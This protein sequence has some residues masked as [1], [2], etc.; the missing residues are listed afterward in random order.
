[1]QRPLR[2]PLACYRCQSEESQIRLDDG[3]LPQDDEKQIPEKEISPTLAGGKHLLETQTQTRL[4]HACQNG[5]I[6]TDGMFLKSP[7]LQP[8]DS[9]FTFQKEL[10]VNLFY[11]A[12]AKGKN[13]RQ[14]T[15]DRGQKE[16][17]YGD[18]DNG[19][20]T[21]KGEWKEKGKS[22]GIGQRED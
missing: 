21:R 1:L 7:D 19:K 14:M 11:K 10:S 9:L 4:L 2:H 22:R 17:T 16:K 6:A 3:A 15:D 20:D 12:N 5:R 8:D 18:D 13:R